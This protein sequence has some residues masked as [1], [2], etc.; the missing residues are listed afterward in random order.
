M[1]IWTEN[2][3]TKKVL[4]CD[5]PLTASGCFLATFHDYPQRPCMSGS[6]QKMEDLGESSRAVC[7]LEENT[8]KIYYETGQDFLVSIPVTLKKIWPSKYGLLLERECQSV[9]RNPNG[10]PPPKMPVWFAL[11][12]PLDDFSRIIVRIKNKVQELTSDEQKILFVSE[13][14][15]LCVT[16]NTHT[17][18]H[19]V[20]LIG[21]ATPEDSNYILA[22]T[23]RIQGLMDPPMTTPYQ[24]P[25]SRHRS[26]MFTPGNSPFSSRFVRTYTNRISCSLFL[27]TRTELF[28]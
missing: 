9:P 27:K 15:S 14:P 18:Q 22:E 21:P 16:V 1:A 2:D 8:L 10:L 13:D 19:S 23:S 11:L 4:K 26:N 17:G 12:H 5:A 20:W 28:T 24:S 6:E 3:H 7:L 25:M